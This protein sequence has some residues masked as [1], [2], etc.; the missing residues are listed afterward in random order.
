MM[1]RFIQTLSNSILPGILVIRLQVWILLR[2]ASDEGQSFAVT[3]PA[4]KGPLVA[5]FSFEL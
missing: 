4:L 5:H 2:L 1:R 3:S